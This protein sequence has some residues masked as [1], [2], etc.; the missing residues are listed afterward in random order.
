[1]DTIR[2]YI[3]NQVAA[4]KLAVEDA[5]K[6]LMELSEANNDSNDV[7][8]I[9]ISGYFPGAANLEEFW[10]NLRQGRECIGEFP[11]SRR[12]D[13]DHLFTDTAPGTDHYSRYGYLDEIDK[14]DAV[15]F[16]LSLRDARM[17]DPCQRLFLETAWEALE[18]AGL[19]GVEIYGGKT[20]VFV[21]KAHFGEFLYND[22]FEEY[23][24]EA[25]TGSVTGLLATR[26]A[27]LLN[28]HG[29]SLVVDT[30]CSSGLVA[31]H[32]ACQSL[33]NKEC[34]LAIA[35]GIS[36]NFFPARKFRITMLESPEGKLR[37]F[38]KNSNGTVWGEGVGAV[39]LKPLNQAIADN[40]HIYAMIKASAVNNDGASNGITAP[41]AVAQEELLADVWQKAKI[42]PETISYIEAHAT[43]TPLGDPIEIKGL[44]NAFRRFTQKK[45]FCNIGTL[46]PN[47]G[48]TVAASGI[49]SLLKVILALQN[50]EIPPTINFTDPNQFINIENLPVFINNKLLKWER[51]GNHPRRAG[52]NSFGISGTNCHVLIEETP[53]TVTNE[54]NQVEHLNL[55]ALSAKKKT[56]LSKLLKC[57]QS[58]LRGTTETLDDI[59]FTANTGRNHYDYRLV[60]VVKSLD[61]LR[62]K[63]DEICHRDFLE[64]DD[65]EIYYG[66]LNESVNAGDLKR[67]LSE[68]KLI[69]EF[70][71]I[72]DKIDKF[73]T[74]EKTNFAILKEI[75]AAYVKGAN[76]TWE[77]L[78]RGEARKKVKLPTYPFDK[79]RFWVDFSNSSKPGFNPVPQKSFFSVKILGRT[80]ESQYT[81]LEKQVGRIWGEVLGVHEVNIYDNFF[82]LGGDSIALIKL[83]NQIRN[84][85]EID[86]NINIFNQIHTVNG[87][88]EFISNYQGSIL[89]RVY[90]IQDP[91]PGSMYQE[92]PLTEVQMAYL[93]GQEN[94]F[95]MGGVSTHVYMEIESFLDLKRLNES[96]L[97]VIKRHPMFRTI[98]LPSGR[99]KILE[100]V[101]DYVIEIVDLSDKD[102]MEQ[103]K[104]IESVRKTMSHFVFKT[105]QWPL[106]EFKAFKINSNTSY[107]F[108]G[109]DMLIADGT[110]LQIFGK[111]LMEY[112]HY[113]ELEKPA[114]EFTFRDYMMA[115]VN[116]KNSDIYQEDK[117][118]WLEKLNDFPPS[119]ALPL[120]CNPLQITKPHFRRLSKEFTANEWETLKK[121][122]RKHTVTPSAFLG[123][124]YA[125]VLAFWS[126]Q[127]HL[128]I[129]L[130][131]FNRFPFHKEVNQII[132]D[133]TSIMLLDI[134]LSEAGSFWEKV[135]NTQNVLMEALEHRHYDGV[136]F[137]REIAKLN[138]LG[139]KAIM[140][141]VFT[142]MLFSN[143][144][145]EGPDIRKELGN[146]KLS[147]SQTPQVYIDCQ[148]TQYQGGLL[149]TWDFV[150]QIFETGMINTMFDQF[151]QRVNSVIHPGTELEMPC[152]HGSLAIV[153]DYNRTEQDIPL[154]T[155]DGL[156]TERTKNAPE[157]PA[158]ISGNQILTY[159][160]LD[161]K[162]NQVAH[163]LKQAGIQSNDRVGVLARRC[164]ETII[165]IV[166]V[167]KAG[168]A[169][170]P[171]DPEYPDERKDYIISN[172]QCKL[173]LVPEFYDTQNLKEC[174]TQNSSLSQTNPA[175]IAYIIY[176]SGST[177]QPKGVV[178]TH[179]AAANTIIDI[180][181]K[182]NLSQNDRIICLS[183]M[184]FDLSVYDI[185]G[186][187]SSGAAMVLIPD[188][189]DIRSI[190]QI[191]EEHK[192][193][194]WNS[195]PAIMDMLV[196]ELN[197]DYRNETLR[198]VLLSGDWI[199]LKLPDKI[200]KHF[201]D[202]EII[203]LG[204]ATE[205]AIWSIYYPVKEIKNTWKS[206]PYGW[207]LANQKLYVLNYEG[208][209]CPVGVQGELYIGGLGLTK[210][211]FN[212]PEKTVKA[213][214]QHPSLGSL[215]RTGDYGIFQ[216]EG[217]I[218]F[219][220]RRDNQIKVRG[221]RIELG[222]IETRLM[223]LESIKEAIVVAKS[224]QNRKQYLCAYFTSTYEL[225]PS[226]I[227]EHLSK[228]LPDYMIPSHFVRL[229][230]FPLNS[231]GK[232]DR[233]ALPGPEGTAV[234]NE[235][236]VAPRNDIENTISKI[237]QELLN[238]ENVG[239]YDNFFD[240][241]GDSIFLIK[242]HRQLENYFPGKI[243][244]ADLFAN[245][246]ISKLTA[247]IDLQNG[248]SAEEANI[249]A[250]LFEMFDMI[251]KGKVSIDDALKNIKG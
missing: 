213:F 123:T 236:Y 144:E 3:Y 178:I 124:A 137:I 235:N 237:I 143:N 45:Q 38:D 239:I 163:Y 168:A 74:G 10:Q 233:K 54:T 115:Y 39:I 121:N 47:I 112:Y 95:E 158:V 120:K 44:T 184:C 61:D 18:D 170:V 251:E 179:Q 75:A 188:L 98:I 113:P 73:V 110:S 142:S 21:G 46:K 173:I 119:P 27:Y 92:F 126:N 90:P 64:V 250:K 156:F 20:G 14:F 140:P 217:F 19:S 84:E 40:D 85:L 89:K 223:V 216:K 148:A 149:I 65:N 204:G 33:H 128:A 93:I 206:I 109:I 96:L 82:E 211:Y 172:S 91:D 72:N 94:A 202:P 205:A 80:A 117:R 180:N 42:D 111:E 160:Q 30:A 17:M 228:S 244:V 185:F 104:Y 11:E 8:I 196:K 214:I 9:G 194:I 60:F 101:P 227:R 169:Y 231:N 50:K 152:Y 221:Y 125:E 212:D 248:A 145:S 155:L 141:Y 135:R 86:L 32:M 83:I 122:I 224:D 165:N 106:F 5:E 219:L 195:V 199:P 153:N 150:D 203:S 245:P 99:Q 247:F 116:F 118:Y 70:P 201:G 177:G 63:I 4:K 154:R 162:S 230:K 151:I 100:A 88:V 243:K 16:N 147:V 1:M 15:F 176:T 97:R 48:H 24:A 2:M 139:A 209:I 193:T 66:E 192:I 164:I 187:L 246:S 23:E 103:Q 240:L 13:T 41:N 77:R 166:G 26:I 130:T 43:G 56:V 51:N 215:Y 102:E 87:L 67:E 78:Y 161:Q 12:K 49:A 182:F 249:E 35:G 6:M 198:L 132:G 226:E 174:P 22:F 189:R 52:I 234:T 133:F 191:V 59:C 71:G 29:P 210:G 157:N 136:E 31:V 207:P 53:D 241:G 190:L 108:M 242:F 57:Y 62:V 229:D 159:Q 36:L 76:I 34:E 81:A 238:I 220:G 55:F 222:E 186:A 58:F 134:N 79:E 183:S 197:A 225:K 7:A 146:V 127:P 171:I 25:F 131:L 138:N 218:E 181:Q 129:D 69:E 105:D 28:L 107:L 37:P 175:D 68:T 208:R 167:L 232:I 200:K 114:I